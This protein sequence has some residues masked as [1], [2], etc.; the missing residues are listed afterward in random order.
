MNIK[1]NQIVSR[2][3]KNVFETADRRAKAGEKAQF[4]L[5]K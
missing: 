1:H 5:D 3:L 4:M 2:L